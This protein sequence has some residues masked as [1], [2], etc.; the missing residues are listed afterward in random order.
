MQQS[1][2]D[3]QHDDCIHRERSLAWSCIYLY[4]MGRNAWGL[5]G[6]RTIGIWREDKAYLGQVL[7]GEPPSAYA[8]LHHRQFRMDILPC[9]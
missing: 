4:N 7:D 2:M 8:Y 9:E 3:A 1:P 5:Y 6:N